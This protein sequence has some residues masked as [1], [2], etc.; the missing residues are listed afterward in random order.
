MS[1]EVV[2]HQKREEQD[3]TNIGE[4]GKYGNQESAN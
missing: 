3:K 4:E 2:Y 1:N